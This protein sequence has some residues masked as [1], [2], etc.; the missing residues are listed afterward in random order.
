MR[1][2]KLTGGVRAS[3][4]L[5]AQPCAASSAS[6]RDVGV[7]AAARTACQTTSSHKAPD[8]RTSKKFKYDKA[9]L[10]KSE[11][12]KLVP[13][14]EHAASPAAPP[15]TPSKD[16]PP[17]SAEDRPALPGKDAGVPAA[18]APAG[19]ALGHPRAVSDG[20]SAETEEGLAPL[21]PSTP[22][23]TEAE[24]AAMRGGCV[25]ALLMDSSVFLDD[26]SSQPMPV[27]RFFGNVEL[28]QDLPPA[29]SSCPS[30]SRREFRKMHFRAKEEEEEEEEDA[31]T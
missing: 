28:M 24:G 8:R 16:A 26:D 21:Q 13:K 3:A 20:R 23:G 25:P 31:E 15:E 27:G 18:Q 11:L 12:Q 10:V 2:R 1:S 22:P 14:S 6:A 19:P 9:H 30:V 17:A 7:T 29:S 4:R 5:R